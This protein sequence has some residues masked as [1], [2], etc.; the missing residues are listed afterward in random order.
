M[1]QFLA[2]LNYGRAFDVLRKLDAYTAYT[3]E[4][5]QAV[6]AIL[7]E[8]YPLI[9]QKTEQNVFTNHALLIEMPGAAIT[10][11]L[12]FV[13]HLDGPPPGGFPQ[14]NPPPLEE[15]QPFRQPHTASLQRAHVVML[16]EALETLLP[17]GYRPG[18]DLMLALSMDGLCGGEGAKSIASH[19]KARKISPCFVLDFGGYVTQSAFC[20]YLPKNAPLALIGISEKGLLEG[21]VVADSAQMKG[22]AKEENPLTLL[23]RA[24]ARLSRRQRLPALCKSS[25][26]MLQALAKRAPLLQRLLVMKPRL[27][28]PLLTLLWRKRAIMNQFFLSQRTLTGLSSTGLAQTPAGES[29]PASTSLSFR[30][31]TIPGL[32]LGDWKDLLRRR[33]AN[34]NLRMNM[35]VELEH[36]ARSGT[37]GE[38][39]DALETAIEILFDRVVIAPCLSPYV[40]DGRFYT[41]LRG[42]VYRF[43]PFLLN[44]QEALNG[45]CALTEGALQTAV[46]FFRQMLSV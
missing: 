34:E 42:N 3:P 15:G 11:P 22:R 35:E 26:A 44:G 36:S 21:R 13:S 31:T 39:W 1:S 5:A 8:S 6:H 25:E 38:A 41:S 14:E 33:M 10:D 40:T 7:R 23:L 28:F 27:T 32:P 43:S 18:G 30:Q 24:G 19:L 16:L 45:E 37:G 12:V 29:V 20:T 17:E 4:G 46:Q 2:P 9:F